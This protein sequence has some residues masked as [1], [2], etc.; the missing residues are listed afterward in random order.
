MLTFSPSD[1]N[2]SMAARIR[3]ADGPYRLQWP[4][5]PM[6]WMGTPFSSRSLASW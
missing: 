2:F 3:S 5:M 4:C 1:A 6:P